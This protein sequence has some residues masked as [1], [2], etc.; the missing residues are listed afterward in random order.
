MVGGVAA[1]GGVAPSGPAVPFV[2]SFAPASHSAAPSVSASAKADPAT[3]AVTGFTASANP[4]RHAPF[5]LYTIWVSDPYGAAHRAYPA[6]TTPLN[7][8]LE[9]DATP[10]YDAAWYG[11][12][13][14]IVPQD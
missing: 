7:T 4:A 12:Y 2:A 13:I 11:R 5:T 3:G 10:W 8:Y 9:T 1:C 6:V 14:V